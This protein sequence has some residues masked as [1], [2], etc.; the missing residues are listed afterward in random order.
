MQIFK[1]RLNGIIESKVLSK[2]IHGTE[3]KVGYKYLTAEQQTSLILALVN[4]DESV[5]KYVT[6]KINRLLLDAY[7]SI[8]KAPEIEEDRLELDRM[9]A[10][11]NASR[12][13]D[14]RAEA[15]GY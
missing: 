4:E 5:H 13:A 10:D 11:N 7:E 14:M 6:G 8:T 3:P 2:I 9:I 1:Q 15:R 12:A